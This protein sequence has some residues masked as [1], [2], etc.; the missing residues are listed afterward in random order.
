MP[1]NS[2]LEEIYRVREA[3]SQ[4][5]GDDL[6]KIAELCNARQ[7]ASGRPSVVLPPRR[8]Q[9]NLVPNAS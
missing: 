7:K 9:Q 6:N 2:I 5:C 1:S 3:L 8:P 4:E